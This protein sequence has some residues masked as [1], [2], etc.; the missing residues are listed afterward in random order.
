MY[1]QKCLPMV[2]TTFDI[3][4]SPLVSDLLPHKMKGPTKTQH[5]GSRTAGTTPLPCMYTFATAANSYY[6]SLA[7][8]VHP[9]VPA[10]GVLHEKNIAA[11]SLLLHAM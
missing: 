6:N 8:R 2:D 1:L 9:P 5:A 11:N 7:V 10:S 4:P 3:H